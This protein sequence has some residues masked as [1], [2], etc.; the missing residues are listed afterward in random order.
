[1]RINLVIM[2][3]EKQNRK[4]KFGGKYCRIFNIGGGSW[5]KERVKI[6]YGNRKTD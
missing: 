1:M 6:I 5:E 3:L 2:Q 4:L